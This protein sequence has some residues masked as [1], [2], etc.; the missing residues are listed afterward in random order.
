MEYCYGVGQI[1]LIAFLDEYFQIDVVD[2]AVTFA[3]TA[4]M[5]A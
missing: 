5:R 2:H 4:D 1:I 3:G